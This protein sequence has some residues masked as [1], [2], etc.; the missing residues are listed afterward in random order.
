MIHLLVRLKLTQRHLNPQLH[1]QSEKIKFAILFSKKKVG[2][3]PGVAAVAR[4]L[5]P[6]LKRLKVEEED[7]R[8][9]ARRSRPHP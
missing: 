5:T 2:L 7:R 1:F 4:P 8:G 3:T 9:A 6:H